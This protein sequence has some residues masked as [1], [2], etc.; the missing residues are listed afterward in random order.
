MNELK[1]EYTILFNGVTDAIDD[2]QKLVVRMQLLQQKAEA[3]VLE[4][5]E[6]AAA[7]SMPS[8]K[9]LAHKAPVTAD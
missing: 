5:E 7:H 4:C 1:K 6:A 9:S 2:L 8:G 3:A